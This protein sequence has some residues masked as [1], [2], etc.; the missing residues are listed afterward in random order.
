MKSLIFLAFFLVVFS[1]G[2]IPSFAQSEVPVLVQP[3]SPGDGRAE[4]FEPRE[5]PTVQRA[6]FTVVNADTMSRYFTDR[7]ADLPEDAAVLLQIFEDVSFTLVPER[8]Q[9]TASAVIVSGHE[10]S[11]ANDRATVVINRD[12]LT[13]DLVIDG[14]QFQIRALGGG[15]QSVAE[16]RQSGFVD[17]LLPTAPDLKDIEDVPPV[18]DNGEPPI[19]DVL[20]AYTTAADNAD[21][22]VEG[23]ILAAVEETN[24]SYAQ[25]GVLQRL[26]LVGTLKVDYQESG[27]IETDRN[28]LQ[29]T[30]DG[31]LDQVPPLR[32]ET[33]ADVVSLWVET[34]EGGVCGIAFIMES[35]ST[36][37]SPYAY[38]VVRRECATGYYS[39]GHELG[40]VMGARHDWYVD[41]TDGSPFAYNHAYVMPNKGWRTIMGYNNACAAEGTSCTRI[42]YWSNP[43][44]LLEGTPLGA[45]EGT[46]SA[47]DN[48]RT[49]NTT[50]PTVAAF[51]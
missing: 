33:K 49:L 31:I 23:E 16:I 26:R 25:S 11:D 24:V 38:S 17:E 47:A 37:F 14:T 39:F 43:D 8:I 4:D 35:V 41:D 51:R 10:I 12:Q 7:S 1:F 20:V 15:V 44:V 45:A 48:H 27:D 19:I 22:D 50:G 2:V 6:G 13:A 5:G 34:A 42:Q 28:R 9:A 36:A 30:A 21:G 18:V 46:P 3:L 40:H 32:E 29:A